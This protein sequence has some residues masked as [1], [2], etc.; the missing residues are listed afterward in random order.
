MDGN[1][2][3]AEHIEFVKRI[4]EENARQNKRISMLEEGVDRM[5]ALT[6][7]VERMAV[8]MENMLAAIERQGNLIEKQNERLEKIEKEPAEEHL[9]MKHAVLTAVIG[10]VVGA[11]V[12]AVL[13]L[14]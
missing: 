14:L 3:R 7:S 9:Q 1:I 5:N 2:T 12:T 8:N 11:V 13:A 4:D 6:V 10:T